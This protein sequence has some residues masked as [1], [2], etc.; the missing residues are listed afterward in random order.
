MHPKS[1]S[2]IEKLR[3]PAS[4]LVAVVFLLL[5]LFTVPRGFGSKLGEAMELLGFFLLIVGA[6][7]RVWCAIYISGRKDRSLCREGP[8][9]LSRN[10]LYFFSFVGVVGFFLGLGNICLGVL[11]AATYLW[12]YRLV[13]LSEEKRLR[14]IFASEYDDYVLSTPRFLPTL[15]RPRSIESLTI[16]PRIIERALK[17]IIWFLLAI[18]FIEVLEEIHHSGRMIVLHLPF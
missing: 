4:K 14:L 5:A 16:N 13:I 2:T 15:R 1:S 11:A 7:G 17:E 10:P 3:K 18:I 9:S 12:Y 8:Y 6:L